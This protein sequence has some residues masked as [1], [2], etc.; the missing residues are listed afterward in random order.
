MEGCLDL[1]FSLTLLIGTGLFW[2]T[3]HHF[4][5]DFINVQIYKEEFRRGL[6]FTTEIS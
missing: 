3:L 2:C 5:T 4:G 6:N 1:C